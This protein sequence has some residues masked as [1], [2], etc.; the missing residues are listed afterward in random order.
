MSTHTS[1]T[2][3]L[4]KRFGFHLHSIVFGCSAFLILLFVLLSLIRL[5]EMQKTFQTIETIIA[6]KAGWL[7]V[8]SVNVFLIYVVTVLLSRFGSIKL[9]GKDAKPDFSYWGWYSMLF[10]AGMGI[11][12]LFWSVAEPISHYVSPP[13][14][15]PRTVETARLAQGLTLLHWGVHAWGI[16]ALVGLALAFFAYNK[17]LPL[18]LRS[19]FY[20]LFGEKIYGSLGNIVDIIA[21]ISTLFGVAT[22]LGLGAQQVNAGLAYLFSFPNNTLTQVI[23]IA[24]ITALATLSVVLGLDRGIQRLSQINLGFA[25]MLL[26]FIFSIGPTIHLLNTLIQNVGLYT[27]HIVM[28]G[29]WTEAY[30]QTDWQHDWT[31]FYW[32]WWIAWSPFVG[33]FIAR[34]SRGRTIKEFLV[35]VLLV[36]TVVTMTWITVFGNSALFIE[37]SDSGRIAEA[38]QENVA[39][40][41]FVLLEQFPWSFFTSML[42]IVVVTIFFVTSSDSASFVIDMIT[43]GGHTNPP[44]KQRVFWAITEGVVASILLLGGGLMAFRI[45]S[46]SMGVPFAIVLLIACVSL[47]LGLKGEDAGS[48]TTA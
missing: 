44:V 25:L 45:A 46:I 15:E 37:M 35:S 20:P 4:F 22:S 24:I 3:S 19:V 29:T 26:L 6:E 17:G 47:W 36:P 23:L 34:I 18:S 30:S 5:D 13:F 9:G 31:I 32:G 48:K 27:K 42:G 43:A 7:L 39:V 41:L 16:Y 40:S 33:T 21:T 28:Y 10:S 11:G 38:V 12:L 1:Q 2:T 8:L 14:G